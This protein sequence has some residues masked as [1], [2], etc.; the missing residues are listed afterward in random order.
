MRII[1]VELEQLFKEL[2]DDELA[3]FW[4]LANSPVFNS[5][6]SRH[7]I[8]SFYYSEDIH[9][10]LEKIGRSELV[11][12]IDDDKAISDIQDEKEKERAIF[13]QGTNKEP[14][15]RIP[16]ETMKNLISRARAMN[17]GAKFAEQFIG[18][19][20]DEIDYKIDYSMSEEEKQRVDPQYGINEYDKIK[21]RD[22]MKAKAYAKSVVG[23]ISS[24]Q[25][26]DIK[27]RLEGWRNSGLHYEFSNYEIKD[28]MKN[29]FGEELPIEQEYNIQM[30]DFM[31]AIDEKMQEKSKETQ[32]KSGII[33]KLKNFFRNLVKGKKT[34]ALP[35]GKGNN[36]SERD[37][38]IN[39]V[40]VS[41]DQSNYIVQNGPTKDVQ[42]KK[43]HNQGHEI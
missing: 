31:D 14:V 24:K 13:T 26:G 10:L 38:F 42:D 25:L 36:T 34:K 27:K 1:D 12:R 2:S 6:D 19:S 7:H 21:V 39:S 18:K 5:S 20:I 3:K 32:Y 11:S 9:K 15:R 28:M 4:H 43:D 40:S 33:E 37:A 17:P 16:E 8:N 30:V 41:P 22:I 35:E 29:I 23:N